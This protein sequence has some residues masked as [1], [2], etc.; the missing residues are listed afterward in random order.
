MVGSVG[1]G[2]AVVSFRL[3]LPV[4]RPCEPRIRHERND[5]EVL[6]VAVQVNSSRGTLETYGLCQAEPLKPP[7]NINLQFEL[8]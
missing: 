2:Q 5:P 4:K 3:L 7:H 1:L 6:E 8:Q